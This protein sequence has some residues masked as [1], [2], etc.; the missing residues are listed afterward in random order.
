MRG[1]KD[2]TKI[3]VL[4]RESEN[5]AISRIHEGFDQGQGH[6]G[7]TG[8]LLLDDECPDGG[9]VDP[10]DPPPLGGVERSTQSDQSVPAPH[11]TSD[12]IKS[13]RQGDLGWSGLNLYS[14]SQTGSPDIVS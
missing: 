11:Q 5:S 13:R 9:L 7:Q 12:E 14:P 1:V 8:L 3:S 4:E 6:H 2:R 10:S